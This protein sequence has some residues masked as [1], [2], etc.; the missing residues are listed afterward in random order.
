[1]K[2]KKCLPL[3]HSYE[4]PHGRR[5]MLGFFKIC[6]KCGNTRII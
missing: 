4:R 6:R 1:M 2:G 5:G 3:M